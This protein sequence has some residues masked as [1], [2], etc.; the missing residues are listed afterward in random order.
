MRR[1]PDSL[2]LT[3]PCPLQEIR[4]R[5]VG[6]RSFA[7]VVYA[8][9]TQKLTLPRGVIM[10]GTILVYGNEVMLVTT[11]QLILE[12]AGYQVFCH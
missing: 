2:V 8:S 12:K 5:R 3:F 9:D 4:L 1:L 7:E 10:L 11:R 6:G